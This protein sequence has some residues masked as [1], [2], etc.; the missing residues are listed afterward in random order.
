MLEQSLKSW[1]QIAQVLTKNY[2]KLRKDSKFNEDKNSNN[3]TNFNNI[4][5]FE[6]SINKIQKYINNNK[7][8]VYN[9]QQDIKEINDKTIPDV[10]KY[11]NDQLNKLNKLDKLDN[12]I[13]F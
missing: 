12:N 4:N 7:N 1:T 10:Y 9:L 3:N 5:G 13:I 6:D 8:D 11:I 2:E